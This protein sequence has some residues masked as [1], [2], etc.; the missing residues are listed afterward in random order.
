MPTTVLKPTSK[1]HVDCHAVHEFENDEII[2][3][4]S[5]D[6]LMTMCSCRAGDDNPY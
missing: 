3:V 5:T 1:P 4:A 6:E 2:F